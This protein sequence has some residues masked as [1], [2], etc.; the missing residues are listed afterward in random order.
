MTAD[1]ISVITATWQ[2]HC[3]LLERCLPSVS[4]QKHPNLEHLVGSDGPDPELRKRMECHGQPHISFFELEQNGGH[5][6]HEARLEGLR[7]AQGDWIA[8][9]DDDD[10]YRPE[11]LAIMLA[12][13]KATGA[14][15][16][17][18]RMLI[19]AG[20]RW[21][22][23]YRDDPVECCGDPVFNGWNVTTSMIF[24]HREAFKAATWGTDSFYPDRDLVRAW[25]AAGLPY[26]S[27][28]MVTV[29]MFTHRTNCGGPHEH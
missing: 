4:A 20:Q 18:S 23:Q 11:H 17:Y 10:S 29:D 15:W 25:H 12:A 21:S 26:V 8:W 22:E 9:L 28:P 14:M 13:C 24:S 27:V 7:R 3:V 2:R 1:L 16:G 6:G 5:W 19:G